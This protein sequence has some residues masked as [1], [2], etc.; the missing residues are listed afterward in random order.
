MIK[1]KNPRIDVNTGDEMVSIVPE[2]AFNDGELEI[3]LDALGIDVESLDDDVSIVIQ[4]EGS[5]I[6]DEVFDDE[7]SDEANEWYL[8]DDPY[9]IVYYEFP[10]DD[11]D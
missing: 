7:F 8:N 5:D 1:L 9:R 11:D 4:I 6:D 2:E 10:E 3:D